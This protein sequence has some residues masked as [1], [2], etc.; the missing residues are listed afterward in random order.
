M[1]LKLTTETPDQN[2]K[3]NSKM[4]T[5]TTIENEKDV[6]NDDDEARD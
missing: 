3:L 5:T 4:Q 6:L 1:A 2:D